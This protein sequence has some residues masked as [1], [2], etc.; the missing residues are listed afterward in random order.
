[1]HILV[2]FARH[3]LQ[4]SSRHSAATG[5]VSKLVKNSDSQISSTDEAAAAAAAA[6]WRPR[7][8][9]KVGPSEGSA[10]PKQIRQYSK[11]SGPA[12]LCKLISRCCSLS[13][14]VSKKQ[15]LHATPDGI[16]NANHLAKGSM[17]N[18]WF[19]A[20]RRLMPQVVLTGPVT[21]LV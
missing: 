4:T 15:C 7:R 17:M 2:F 8:R 5:S 16:K 18:M 1:M 21:T 20:P 14:P 19:V 13:G 9:P 12:E 10:C 11:E 6:A 3:G